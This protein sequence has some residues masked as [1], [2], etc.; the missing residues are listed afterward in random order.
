MTSLGKTVICLMIPGALVGINGCSTA[1]ESG[2]VGWRREFSAGSFA[3]DIPFVSSSGKPTTLHSVRKPITILAFTAPSS[4]AC[5]WVRPELIAL[6]GKF[7][8]FPVTVA[9]VSVP[10]SECSHGSACTEA[11]RLERPHLMSLCDTNRAAWNSYRRPQPDTVFLL[12]R[13]GAVVEISH[14]ASLQSIADTAER[15]ALVESEL[16]FGIDD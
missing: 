4:D 10:A 2:M 8:V 15:L 7:K 9:Q 13:H 1:P 6:A 11:C 5:C 16:Q 14:M 12:D 3:P